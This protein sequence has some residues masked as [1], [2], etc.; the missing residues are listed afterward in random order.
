MNETWLRLQHLKIHLRQG[1]ERLK[2]AEN[3]STRDMKSHYQSL[4]IPFWQRENLPYVS[5]GK[6]LLFAAGVGMQ[7]RFCQAV[8]DDQEGPEACICLRWVFDE[9]AI[10]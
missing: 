7:S 4:G 9:T 5:I 1:G 6:D 10:V 2:L 3:R 8:V